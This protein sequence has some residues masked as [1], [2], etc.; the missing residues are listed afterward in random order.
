VFPWVPVRQ[1]VL[2]FPHTLRYR[3]AYDAQLVSDVLDT[4]IKTIF[5]SLIRRAREF[6]ATRRAP[7]GAVTFIQRFDSALG[8]NLH[9]HSLVIDGVYAA[10]EQDNPQFQVLLSPEND[11]IERV[12]E[13][14]AERIPRL[15]NR[16]G[17][18]PDRNPDESDPLAR[19]QPGLATLYAAS[20]SG[21]VA[22]G[23]NAGRRVTRGGDQID[24][25]SI[26]ALGSPRCAS[27]S[28]FSLH[29]NTA[30]HAH[31]RSRLERLI[32]YCARPAIAGEAQA[33]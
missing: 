29:A 23:P 5:A 19:D 9:L 17:L 25:E 2:S 31:D 18:G 26:A 27:V 21:R 8:L 14:L 28:G 7:C 22:F 33:R 12:A 30:V 4:F 15:L 13:R 16:R 24:P 32:Q 1:W 11:E 20:V 6:G 3:L 10:D